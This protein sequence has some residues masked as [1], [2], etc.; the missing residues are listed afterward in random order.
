MHLRCSAGDNVMK[1][2]VHPAVAMQN[3]LAIFLASC[4]SLI[5]SM[6]SSDQKTSSSLI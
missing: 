2:M 1:H 3:V 4:H 5:C 6:L